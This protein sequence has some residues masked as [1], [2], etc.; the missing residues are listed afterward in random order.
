LFTIRVQVLK[1]CR[2]NNANCLRAITRSARVN[3]NKH[4]KSLEN[5]FVAGRDHKE[6]A[7]NVANERLENWEN[8]RPTANDEASDAIEKMRHLRVD[9]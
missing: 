9:R 1:P 6:R 8:A 7:Q 5:L 3:L 4:W 2:D